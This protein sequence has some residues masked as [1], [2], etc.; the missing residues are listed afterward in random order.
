MKR[1]L[2]ILVTALSLFFNRVMADD[3]PKGVHSSTPAAAAQDTPDR[4]NSAEASSTAQE[5][6]KPEELPAARPPA[7]SDPASEA[8]TATSAKAQA[9]AEDSQKSASPSSDPSGESQTQTK[10]AA[11]GPSGST[12][13]GSSAAP[14]L[15]YVE[16]VRVTASRISDSEE[17]ASRVPAHVTVYTREEIEASGAAT[18]QEF[19]AT[20]SDFVVFDEV[21]NGVEATAD[22][23]G[24]N[25]GSLA[26]SA[27][28]AVD[29]VR[30]N[31]PDTGYVNFEL[32]PLSDVERVEVIRGSSSALFGEGGLGGVINVVTRQG[33]NASRLDASVQG[34]SFGTRSATVSSG[35]RTGRLTWY[36][37]LGDR[38]SDG[39]RDN[40]AVRLSSFQGSASWAFSDRQSVGVDLTAESNHL[41]QPGALTAAELREDPTQSPFNQHDFSAT[42]LYLPSLHY[43]LL[44]P[45]GFSLAS[46]LSYRDTSEDG[47]NGGRSGLG[48][49]SAVDRMGLSWTV[50]ASHEKSFGAGSNQAVLGAEL[51]RDRFD[52]GQTRTDAGG[53]I[54]PQS[55]TSYSV[56]SA[57]STRRFAALFVQDTFAF[58][59]RVSVTAGARLDRIGLSSDGNQAF[60]D[61]PPPTFS[62]VFTRSGTGGERSFSQVSPRLGVNFNPSEGTGY[63]AGYSRGFRAPTVIELF[64]FPIFFSN[65]DLRPV[66]SDDYEA[67]WNHRFAGGRS[68][69]AVNAFWIDVKDEIFF[70]MTDPSTFT[71]INLNLPR[72][73]RRGAVLTAGSRLAPR[74]RGEVGVT[75]TDATFRSSFAD[76]NIGSQVEP[77]DRLPQI[78]RLKYSAR[79]D[80][81]LPQ[82]WKAGLQE[83]Y[84]EHQVLTSDLANQAPLLSP[85]NVLNAR[86]SCDRGRWEAF[87]EA[88]NVLDRQYS[89]RGIYA[90][91]FATF[92]FEPFYTPAPGRNI[93]GG[94]RFRY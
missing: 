61:F 21:G 11:Q 52:T 68:T 58:S 45:G 32:I 42:H 76:A 65:P 44:L 47:F 54:L 39:F 66:H 9:A 55:D 24:F 12:G 87:L 67:G 2:I 82:G 23:R 78:P 40:S 90:F 94:L 43:R 30:V 74:L 17:E 18:L 8:G 57:A 59:P 62:P 49:I 31:E 7:G 6:P 36:A 35:A 28:V 77:G 75:Y 72:T 26:T 14:A 83:I 86:V 22:L 64:A 34:G 41:D 25:T 20:R 88:A 37:G 27:L 1:V 73:R 5:A 16:K 53:T 51:S 91:N 89:T 63:Y 50:Q 69:L 85:Y 81:D 29:G 48:S 46:R 3:T 79:L 84:V 13:A 4:G 10:P 15:G 38:A 33:S 80:L 60:Y 92:A 56:S 19:F 71:G 93:F 70:V